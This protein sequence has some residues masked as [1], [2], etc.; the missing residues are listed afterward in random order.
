LA[1][2]VSFAAASTAAAQSAPQPGAKKLE[3]AELISELRSAHKLLAEADRDYDGHRAKAAEEIHKAIREL[4]GKQHAKAAEAG[5]APAAAVV[6]TKPP[7]AKHA[8]AHE[9]QADSDA[10][11]SKA[12][13]ILAGVQAEL[14]AHHPKASANVLAA[15]A[16]INTALRIK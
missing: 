3:K 5:S 8:G 15:I 10:Q 7:K 12:L 4:R 13:A 9:P 11:L 16:E 6:V 1:L 14:T 2:V